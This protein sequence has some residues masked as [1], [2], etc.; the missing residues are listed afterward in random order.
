MVMKKLLFS[1]YLPA[2]LVVVVPLSGYLATYRVTTDPVLACSPS[3]WVQQA[4]VTANDGAAN[5]SLGFSIANDGDSV[6]VGAPEVKIG[7]NKEQ[8]AAYVFVRTAGAWTQ[9]QKLTAND[10]AAGDSFGWSVA[11][12]GDTVVVGALFATVGNNDREG[13]AY[14][15]VRSGGVWTQQAKLTSQLTNGTD[16]GLSD[17]MF[18][19]SVSIDGDSVAVGAPAATNPIA[20]AGND[21]AGALYVYVRSGNTWSIQQKLFAENDPGFP[22][23]PMASSVQSG[24][25]L[26]L[27]VSISGNTI[28]AGGDQFEK[29]LPNDQFP[30]SPIMAFPGA[31]CVFARSGVTWTE[32]QK[33]YEATP[34]STFDG[35]DSDQFG[36]SVSVNGSTF[37]AGAIGHDKD[38]QFNPKGA[39]YVYVLSAGTWVPQQKLTASD[40]AFGDLFGVSV[41]IS[42]DTIVSGISP[43]FAAQGAA[44][45]YER[46][47]GTWTEEQKLTAN[48]G[49]VN[50]EFGFSA[51]ISGDT[52]AAGAQG[53][54]GANAFQ[55]AGYIFVR[56]NPPAAF[57]VTG[58]GAY[59]SGGSGVVVGISG[60][61][62]GVNYQLV[63]N[64]STNVGSPVAGTGSAISF[65]N[66]TAAG[67]YTVVATN[68]VTSCTTNMTGSATVS[69]AQ[70]ASAG[71]PQ[72][73]PPGGT[74]A[75][76]GGNTPVSGTGTW[77][78]QSGGTGTFSS[79][80]AGNSTFTHTGG[81]GPI[82][83]RWTITNSPCPDSFAEV[84]ITLGIQPTINC[85]TQPIVANTTTRACSAPV[86]F[87]VT[88]GGL[89]QPTVTCTPSSGSVF[90]KGVTTVMCTASNGVGNNATCS[91]TVTVNDTESPVFP[92]GC[93]TPITLTA[94]V[95]CPF[96]ASA[97]VSFTTPAATD[98]CSAV[99]VI[100][101]P[102]AGSMFPV[103][104][105]TVTCTA[106]DGSNNTTQC[107]FAVNAFSFCLQ[108]DSNPGNVVLVNA[109]TGD[110]SFCCGGVPIASGRGTL[111]TRGCS[112][113]IDATK[114]DRQV[115]IQWDTAA[116]NGLGAGTAYVQKLS[117]GT[118]CQIT[119]K[120]MSNNT[121][122][123]SNP[124]PPVTPKK[125]PK[126]TSG[127]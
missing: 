78:V 30:D 17:E 2:L 12:S 31:V 15:F 66:Q 26:G 43:G 68:V 5:D 1:K 86:T 87:T 76:L 18:G 122:Q 108:D 112:G 44:Y 75:P 79:L 102:P 23:D 92:N 119:D 21:Q 41:S 83:V 98:N 89:P 35:A 69:I 13:T 42:G 52:I 91:F 59:C 84:T 94:Q 48:D 82:V 38:A 4:K 46:S 28:V 118:I 22:G 57:S 58:G 8:G 63:L 72:T 45:V 10:G 55:G 100:C 110:F 24:D 71:G 51:S 103:G 39:A 49:A 127:T 54:P 126:G 111:T 105:T 114:G 33:V 81:A 73:I 9:Q 16:D 70:P 101:N 11:I 99:T 3:P 95:S 53:A 62:S 65:G 64:G 97:L 120:N 27:S 109:Q 7:G 56:N 34:S 124:P 29:K 106:T 117:N 32:Q 93:G 125:P 80:H 19:R 20:A 60:S 107:A 116:N 40:G 104:T 14:V 77:T 90:P 123:C 50:D 74:T 37:V 121:C 25:N 113:S 85:P 36:T 61:Q 67:T 6:V 96:A 115:H 88:A 47:A